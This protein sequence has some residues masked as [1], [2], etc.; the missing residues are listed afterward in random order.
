MG[1]GPDEALDGAGPQD[2]RG[3]HSAEE[4]VRSACVIVLL[5]VVFGRSVGENPAP[6]QRGEPSRHD[7]PRPA[8]VGQSRG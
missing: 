2:L 8:E 6:R 3:P 1:I 7:V 5:V 4:V